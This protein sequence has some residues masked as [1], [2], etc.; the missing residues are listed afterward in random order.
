MLNFMGRADL[1]GPVRGLR[2]GDAEGL[3]SETAL[4][5]GSVVYEV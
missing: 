3:H 5:G 4:G 2:L 1:P